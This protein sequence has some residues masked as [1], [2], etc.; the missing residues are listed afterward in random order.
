M[1]STKKFLL[2]ILVL[3]TFT[4]CSVIDSSVIDSV[5]DFFESK[6]SIAF[7]NPISKV[8]KADMSVFVSGFPDNWTNDIESHLKYD[9]WQVFDSD[10]GQETF[11][12]VCDRLGQQ[13]WHS[14][15]YDRSGHKSTSVEAQNSFSGSVSVIDLRT[16][17]RVAIYEFMYE[18]AETVISRSV[19]L[20][21]MVINKSREKK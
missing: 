12:L 2:F 21:R 13:E 11:I 3:F 15:S 4:S 7:I 8:K 16:R 19:L 9:N 18:K 17:K 5:S 6:P 10:T 14:E 1:K 20:M